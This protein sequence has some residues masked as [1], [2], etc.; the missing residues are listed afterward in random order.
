M[1]ESSNPTEALLQEA[2]DLLSRV[3]I[4]AKRISSLGELSRVSSSMFVAVYESLFHTRLDAINRNPIIKE[5]YINNVQIVINELSEQIQID[6]KH[7]N[8]E[9][10]AN[11]DIRSISNLLHIFARIFNVTRYAI[12]MNYFCVTYLFYICTFTIH[13]LTVHYIL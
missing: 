6:L 9:D 13:I 3:G 10:I 8:G 12:Y 4:S 11:G 2:N 5:E 7:I 1:S